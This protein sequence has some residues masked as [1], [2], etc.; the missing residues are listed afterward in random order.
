MNIEINVLKP[1]LCKTLLIFDLKCDLFLLICCNAV[2][3]EGTVKLAGVKRD[4][5]RVSRIGREN[6]ERK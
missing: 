1:T 4:Y 3:E 5:L 2:R 6:K